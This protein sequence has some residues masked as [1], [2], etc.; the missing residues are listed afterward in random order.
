MSGRTSP[1]PSDE[2]AAF[3]HDALESAGVSGLCHEGCLEVA[4]SQVRLRY[5][6]ID[7]ETAWSLVRAIDA[8]R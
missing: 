5:P 8:E 3:I 6:E 7:T 1:S 2:V 4:V